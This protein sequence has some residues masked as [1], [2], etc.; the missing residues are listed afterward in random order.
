VSL[1]LA[2]SRDTDHV[3]NVLFDLPILFLLSQTNNKQFK[4]KRA[5]IKAVEKKA[6]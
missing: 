3:R 5:L 4:R 1:F 6:S 2:L